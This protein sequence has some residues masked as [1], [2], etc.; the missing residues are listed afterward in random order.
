MT[1]KSLL[2]EEAVT[3]KKT[4]FENHVKKGYDGRGAQVGMPKGRVRYSGG[5]GGVEPTRTFYDPSKP[6]PNRGKPYTGK[7]PWSI[8]GKSDAHLKKK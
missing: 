4:I 5:G 2:A 1:K 6:D 8:P 7:K 3:K